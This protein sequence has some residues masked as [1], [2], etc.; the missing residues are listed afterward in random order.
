MIRQMKTMTPI[1]PRADPIRRSLCHCGR[2]AAILL[3]FRREVID[4]GVLKCPEIA[5]SERMQS[6]RRF[7]WFWPG[8]P[9]SFALIISTGAMPAVPIRVCG[10]PA[11]CRMGMAKTALHQQ[12]KIPL[13]GLRTLIPRVGPKAGSA[14]AGDCEA[15]KGSGM[16][17]LRRG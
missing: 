8:I 15:A 11:T 3:E 6:C 1:H 7:G 12:A 4:R 9:R 16:R 17:H 10:D 2:I 14:S 5:G 13:S